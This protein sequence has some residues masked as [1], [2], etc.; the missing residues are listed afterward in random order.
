MET[1][2]LFPVN[3]FMPVIKFLRL[4]IFFILRKE[5][6]SDFWSIQGFSQRNQ[7]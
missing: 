6:I 4:T 5:A 7:Q 1:I 3:I 2:E